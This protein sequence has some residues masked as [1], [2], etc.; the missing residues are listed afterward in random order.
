MHY[1]DFVLTYFCIHYSYFRLFEF[2]FVCL[3]LLL[4][5]FFWLILLV[6]EK[7]F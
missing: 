5:C 4:L 3:L 2:V 1:S 6:T 7:L